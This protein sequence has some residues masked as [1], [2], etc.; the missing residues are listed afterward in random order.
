M[1]CSLKRSVQVRGL[2]PGMLAASGSDSEVGGELRVAVWTMQ[3]VVL[4]RQIVLNAV[5]RVNHLKSRG[6]AIP[7]LPRKLTPVFR[8]AT[9]TY[10]WISPTSLVKLSKLRR[11]EDED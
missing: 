5:C 9:F 2:G 8:A 3:T 7:M 1:R 6:G 10:V 4:A 11:D